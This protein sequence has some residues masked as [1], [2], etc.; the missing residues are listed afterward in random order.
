MTTQTRKPQKRDEEYKESLRPIVNEAMA[1][2]NLAPAIV[3]AIQ[4][5]KP[6]NDE[7]KEMFRN[8]LGND[9]EFNE[10]LETAVIDMIGN[11]APVQAAINKSVSNGIA[12]K[13]SESPT[14]TKAFWI[15]IIVSAI[16]ALAAVAAV[17]VSVI[18]LNVG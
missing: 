5:N 6:L 12:I 17:V 2:Q 10:M 13:K 16:G 9:K 4:Q 18:A 14:K 3:E 15:P 7:L 1:A 11:S 8:T